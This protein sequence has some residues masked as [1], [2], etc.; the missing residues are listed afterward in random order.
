MAAGKPSPLSARLLAAVPP[1]EPPAAE[2][3]F[4]D[5]EVLAR[6]R[7]NTSLKGWRLARLLGVGPVT[8]CYEVVRGTKDATERAA[9][10]VM[11]GN[12][13]AHE[14][15]RSI[16]LRAA[17]AANRFQ[18]ARVLP[19][20]EDGTDDRGVAYVVRPWVDGVEPLDAY[21]AKKGGKLPEKEVLRI[22]EQA[23]D[24]LEMAH[25]HGILH[26][27]ITPANLL[28][29][30]RG[31]VRLCDFAT[32]PGLGAR[33]AAESE[34]LD[35]RRIGPFTAPER[36]GETLQAP[37]EQCDVWSLAACLYYAISGQVPQRGDAN[38]VP[39]LRTVAEGVSEDLVALVDQGLAFDPVYRYESAYAML[40]DVRRVMA[41][42]KPK[43][44]DAAGPIPSQSLMD[45]NNPPSSRALRA[46]Q[47]FG[48]DPSTGVLGGSFTAARAKGRRNEWR[49]N[50]ALILAIAALVGVA[51]FV[52]VR[53]K[54]EEDRL[55]EA[56]AR[57][58]A[59]AAASAIP[60]PAPS[61]TPTTP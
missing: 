26:G 60:P 36:A 49:G 24:A 37:A 42:R 55:D 8:A 53:E 57:A 34:P 6:A 50:A 5:R 61:T 4:A 48:A 1:D 30:P 56:K 11:L 7:V 23:L 2:L 15:S 33:A 13:A 45:V 12:I 52:V 19:I 38:G 10:K 14:R 25:A 29:T 21:L 59:A 51:T 39:S 40:G 41:G 16:F 20:V 54:I 43:L 18:H 3:P 22:A 27:A 31:S 35:R 28:V 58:R 46:A 47:P 32:P 17:Y 44:S 9:L